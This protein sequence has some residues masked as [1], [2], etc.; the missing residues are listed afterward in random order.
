MPNYH[1]L[2]VELTNDKQTE[3][4]KFNSGSR[5]HV[6]GASTAAAYEDSGGTSSSKN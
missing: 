1:I 5:D 2:P 6:R 3:R 4:A